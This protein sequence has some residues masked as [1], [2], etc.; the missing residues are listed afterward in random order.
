M[1]FRGVEAVFN[2]SF[3]AS[4]QGIPADRLEANTFDNLKNVTATK[5]KQSKF[6]H[7]DRFFL[8]VGRTE[9]S[10]NTDSGYLS[11]VHALTFTL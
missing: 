1:V 8:S 10:R 5:W 4:S 7:T 6:D 11:L 3:L 9:L 2:K